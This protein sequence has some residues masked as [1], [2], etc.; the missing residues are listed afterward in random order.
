MESKDYKVVVYGN[1]IQAVLAA[2]KA[3]QKLKVKAERD[4]LLIVPDVTGKLGGIVTVGGQNFWDTYKDRN[5]PVQQG[6]FKWI[7]NT[8]TDND[9]T[10]LGTGYNINRLEARLA[11]S[12]TSQN[13]SVKKQFGVEN[14]IEVKYQTDVVD[15]ET[16]SSGLFRI[17]ALKLQSIRRNSSTGYVEWGPSSSQVRVTGK[18]FIDA[19]EEGRLARAVNSVVTT[20][21]YDWPTTIKGKQVLD[22]VDS[23]KPYV[24]RQQAATLMFQVKGVTSGSGVDRK[25]YPNEWGLG[26][27]WGG[28][29]QFKKNATVANFNNMAGQRTSGRPQFLLKPV[30][31][32]RNGPDGSNPQTKEWWMNSLLI[33]DVDG[34]V[35]E[36]DNDPNSP[37]YARFHVKDQIDGTWSTDKAWVAARDFLN[38]HK[39]EV[40]NALRAMLDMP[41]LELVVDSNNKVVVGDV[42]YLRETV[43]MSMKADSR[44]HNSEANYHIRSGET[45]D[46]GAGPGTGYD[47]D[48]GNYPTRIGLAWYNA[49]IHPYKVDDVKVGDNYIWNG[50]NESNSFVYKMRPDTNWEPDN[51]VYVP[52][53][54]MTTDYVAN[55]L[56]CGYA[57]N[58]GSYPWAEVRV[59]PNLCVL[60]DAAGV[61]AAYAVNNNINPHN[62]GLTH[63]KALQTGFLK[64]IGARLEK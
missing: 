56:L 45:M 3:A 61:A 62:P 41:S 53:E 21:R 5:G 44:S 54:A 35:N 16:S 43:H 27:I 60:G 49:D 9:E 17:T 40:Q 15:Y 38:G 57:V 12:I 51:P 46:A 2:C 13:D 18:V 24:G 64:E 7:Y 29:E 22:D 58:V 28:N 39:T 26:C 11:D 48:Y 31:M 37:S 23:Q 36:R 42:L 19:S 32:A 4:V 1:G 6:S 55:L 59:A 14:Q 63:I 20:G 47:K 33:F 50:D 8:G 25:Y 10:Y 30:N 34:R 52:Y